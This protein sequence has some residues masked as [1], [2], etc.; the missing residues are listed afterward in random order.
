MRFAEASGT[1][2]TIMMCIV[3][4]AA[5]FVPY[6]GAV[7]FDLIINIDRNTVSSI[8][9]VGDQNCVASMR[10]DNKALMGSVFDIVSKDSNDSSCCSEW[11]IVHSASKSL[12]NSHVS[13]IAIFGAGCL[14]GQSS[15]E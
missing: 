12:F 15:L 13:I 8:Q 1:F 9:I 10:F 7:D 4:Q 14:L 11:N 5:V 2:T 3:D 6:V